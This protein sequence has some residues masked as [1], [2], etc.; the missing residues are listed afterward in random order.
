MTK[1]APEAIAFPTTDRRERKVLSKTDRESKVHAQLEE[2]S[3]FEDEAYEDD[4]FD[5]QSVLREFEKH[6]AKDEETWD[7][8][9]R[10]QGGYRFG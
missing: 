8:P 4:A 9:D 10:S 1:R 6:Y 2:N 5:D 3:T 7:V